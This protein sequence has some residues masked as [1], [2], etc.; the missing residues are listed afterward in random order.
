MKKNTLPCATILLVGILTWTGCIATPTRPAPQYQVQVQRL[1]AGPPPPVMVATDQATSRTTVTGDKPS[2]I[3][4]DKVKIDLEHA[5]GYKDLPTTV[6]IPYDLKPRPLSLVDVVV[7]TLAN[8]RQIKVQDYTLRIAE[9]QI[10]VSKGIYDLL[11][12]ATLQFDRIEQQ[13]STSVGL[14]PLAVSSI[15]NRTAQ[16][17]LSQLFPSGAIVT[18]G[19]NVLRQT[20][21]SQRFSISPV[22][23][24]TPF[25]SLTYQDT[26]MVSI[27]Q[28]L[29]K[30]FGPA[31]TNAGIR[32]AQL[33][34]QGS[35]ADFQTQVELQLQNALQTYWDLIGAYEF[36]KVQVISYAAALDLLRINTAKYKAGVLAQ[37]D[38]LQAQAAAEARRNQVIVAR[39]SIRDIEDALKRLLFLREGSPDW[40]AELAPSQAI[41]WR[42][43]AVDLDKTIGVALA[44][45]SELR[46]ADSNILQ[47]RVNQVVARSEVL[48]EVNLFGNVSPNGLGSGFD[49][50]FRNMDS[51]KYISYSAGVEFNYPLQNRAARYRQKQ[52][53]ART[54]QAE[55]LMADLR[56]QVTLE[57][58]QSVR[59][60]KSARD[61]IAVT[62][63][64]VLS[65]EA[66]LAAEMKRYEVG[67]S[68]AFEVLT[69]QN[70]LANAQDSHISAVVS[71]NK[72]AIRLERARGTLLDTYGIQVAGVDLNP[73]DEPI[74][75]PVGLN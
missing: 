53:Q 17:G 71:Y 2:Q 25:T 39:Q 34:R 9:Y 24:A 15:R 10:P 43:F 42:E 73:P 59:A 58:R 26:S 69:F 75:F 57:V 7:E 28:P 62:Q 65:E 21:L 63:A 19:Y 48:P 12:S 47:A 23:S 38:V 46:R 51:G 66:K 67:I 5:V 29:L 64:Q 16:I 13:Q 44:R 31:V 27:V 68:T 18:A 20:M 74:G 49:E 14:S 61:Q 6:T 3:V 40:E 37:T 30:G 60:L 52:A 32:I 36:Y 55:E 56:D 11:A 45:R 35:A 8:N 54:D 33:E 22:F 70:D 72:A 41:A 50:G 1:D 4:Q